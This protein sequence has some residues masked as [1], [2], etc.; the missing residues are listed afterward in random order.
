MTVMGVDETRD[1]YEDQVWKGFTR[2]IYRKK[3][4]TRE[5]YLRGIL[6]F[7]RFHD[8]TPQELI[9]LAKESENK[10]PLENKLR[11]S[12]LELVD[13]MKASG[14][15]VS[16]IQSS[17]KGIK[18]FLRKMGLVLTLDSDD[19]REL[20]YTAP[21][22]PTVNADEI[23]RFIE[24]TASYRLKAM[25]LT[26]KDTG[27]R[28]SDLVEIER[29]VVQDCINKGKE[30]CFI[31]LTT[32]K[33]DSNAY[34]T[35]GPEALEAIKLYLEWRDQQ[36][37][38]DCPYL[39]CYEWGKNRG[40]KMRPAG[41]ASSIDILQKKTGIRLTMH[42]LRRFC[43]SQLCTVMS[44]EYVKYHTGKAVSEDMKNYVQPNH[45][46][47][48]YP[49]HY[50]VL[51]IYKKT[52][53]EERVEGLELNQRAYESRI[54]LLEEELAS[55]RVMRAEYEDERERS[56]AYIKMSRDTEQKRF[57]DIQRLW[58]KNAELRA[59][60]EASKPFF[61]L[62]KSNPDLLE[63]LKKMSNS[64]IGNSNT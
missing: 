53:D 56:L 63:Q 13:D 32:M 18:Y 17:Q 10:P 36:E 5:N 20:K 58:K 19:V 45:L 50:D 47:E 41:L 38:L 31:P 2:E 64:K 60:L 43:I 1:L 26:A 4:N 30:F 29:S 59:S 25:I 54:K 52:F 34:T 21:P 7:L 51:R 55:A 61:D 44:T 3:P 15:S 48:L 35:I 39:F 22:Q 14:Y 42:S 28:K 11:N 9:D 33:T 37:D 24:A 6:K 12:F 57:E 49:Q 27:L 46:K 23:R 16:T 40:K 8:M 62:L